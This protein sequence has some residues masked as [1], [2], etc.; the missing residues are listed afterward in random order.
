MSSAQAFEDQSKKKTQ[1]YREQDKEKRDA[2]SKEIEKFPKEKR[3][4]L[5]ESGLCHRLQRTHGYAPL[6][7]KKYTV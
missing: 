2:Y 5:D 7:E 1:Q 4:Y 3:I 6:K